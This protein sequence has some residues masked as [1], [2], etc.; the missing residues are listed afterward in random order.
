MDYVYAFVRKDISIVHQ[1]VQIGHACYEAGM[2][3]GQNDTNLILLELENEAEIREWANV[4][5]YNEIKHVLFYEPDEPIGYNAICTEPI[6]GN[7]RKIFK[8]CKMWSI[9]E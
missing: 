4:L 7:K 6:S 1:M 9:L 2:L 8:N 3:Y 5:N